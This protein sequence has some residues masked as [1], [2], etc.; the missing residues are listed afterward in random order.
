GRAHDGVVL[1]IAGTEITA[2]GGQHLRVVVHDEQNRLIH[3]ATPPLPESSTGSDT[4]NSVRFGCDSTSMVLSLWIASRRTMSRP[5]PMPCPIGLV[6]KKGSKMRSSTAGAM[7][8]P[9]SIM[10]TTT[11]AFSRLADTSM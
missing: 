10:R 8:G 9:L 7:P 1:P 6:E 3:F 2:D 4:R 11:R 5:R